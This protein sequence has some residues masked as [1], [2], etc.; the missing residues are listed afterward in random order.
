MNNV[1]TT[2][3]SK[4]G[5]IDSYIDAI[6]NILTM[7]NATYIAENYEKNVVNDLNNLGA[8]NGVYITKEDIPNDRG[9]QFVKDSVNAHLSKIQS[10]Q[11]KNATNIEIDRIKSLALQNYKGKKITIN[12]IDPKLDVFDAVYIDSQTGNYRVSKFT[13]K[14]VK[15]TV[16]DINYNN[17][18]LVIKPSYL[19][20]K[21]VPNRILIHVYV[22]DIDTLQP[23]VLVT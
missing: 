20:R 14:S 22:L 3:L 6:R 11:I 5:L 10:E 15:G 12:K 16:E 18:L 9:E 23:N 19:Y 8:R 17:N 4:N 7:Q 1:D 21:L 2:E 13:S